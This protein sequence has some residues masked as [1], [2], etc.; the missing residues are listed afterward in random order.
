MYDELV[1]VEHAHHHRAV[2]LS[3]RPKGEEFVTA[4][5]LP[6]I[7]HWH[8]YTLKPLRELLQV[9]LPLHN[10][11]IFVF[12]VV[13][14]NVDVLIELEE[15][16]KNDE[17]ELGGQV[18][19]QSRSD[20]RICGP[21]GDVVVSD[22]AKIVPWGE[23]LVLLPWPHG[24]LGFATEI[25]PGDREVLVEIVLYFE[26]IFI[27]LVLS[28]MESVAPPYAVRNVLLRENDRLRSQHYCRQILG[29]GESDSSTRPLGV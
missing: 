24:E 21:V 11:Y 26:D 7:A 20:V 17:H 29:G 3:S 13:E 1:P 23:D 6:E 16:F 27:D 4:W 18:G 15:V 19:H 9:L 2:R 8:L 12:V 28:F 10:E 22:L 14:D 5:Q 25:H